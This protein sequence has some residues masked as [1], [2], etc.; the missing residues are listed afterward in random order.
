[1]PQITIVDK[2]KDRE[3]QASASN[4]RKR[5]SDV[6]TSLVDQEEDAEHTAAE[7]PKVKR[8]VGRPPGKRQKVVAAAPAKAGTGKPER[9]PRRSAYIE[10]I[11]TDQAKAPDQNGVE[12]SQSGGESEDDGSLFVT[13]TGQAPMHTRSSRGVPI[14]LPVLGADAEGD[15]GDEGREKSQETGGAEG[16]T[17]IL[18]NPSPE[19]PTPARRS[20]KDYNP[21]PKKPVPS[22]QPMNGSSSGGI[23]GSSRPALEAGAHGEDPAEE[24]E[25][26]QDEPEDDDKPNFGAWGVI[27]SEITSIFGR[28]DHVVNR[29]GCYEKKTAELVKKTP[30]DLAI[31][32][33]LGKQIDKCLGAL[34]RAY[35]DLRAAY[36]TSGDES[37]AHNSIIE[38]F[39]VMQDLLD[40]TRLYL[41]DVSNNTESKID[42]MKDLLFFNIPEFTR[43]LRQAFL[44]HASHENIPVEAQEE[45]VELIELLKTAIDITLSQPDELVPKNHGQTKQ[46]LRGIRSLLRQL[47]EIKS[48]L[49]RRRK[50]IEQE[51][52]IARNR[53]LA[54]TWEERLLK[55]EQALKEEAAKARA[56]RIK[57]AKKSYQNCSDVVRRGIEAELRKRKEL[58]E[59]RMSQS[60]KERWG[61]QDP[62]RSAASDNRG[63]ARS[64]VVEEDGSRVVDD[65]DGRVVDE[66]DSDD[67]FS[68]NYIPR[69]EP[70]PRSSGVFAQY[71]RTRSPSPSLSIPPLSSS[72]PSASP[73]PIHNPSE[74][75]GFGSL[76]ES[77]QKLF[78]ATMKWKYENHANETEVFAHL[79]DTIAGGRYELEDIW[80]VAKSLQDFF[81][82]EHGLGRARRWAWSYEVWR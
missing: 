24:D 64:R 66:D 55:E 39:S 6:S 30:K 18:M 75:F 19:K 7:V 38:Q 70:P 51:R 49:A 36:E 65:D 40:R 58:E 26:G 37:I 47:L 61:T 22:Q 73:E 41:A 45:M 23:T 33:E 1:V 81:D 15:T 54:R 67:P 77:D 43:R 48:E 3:P 52:R 5:R 10:K 32:T 69:P 12:H 56:E 31:K 16:L 29:L 17:E 62:D 71:V 50:A 4:K 76:A 44:S 20:P 68:D 8:P 9:Q 60:E 57:A 21:Q 27:I 72:S 25:A 34:H 35:K 74:P 82:G 79:K 28:L 78:I 2:G 59:W 42:L 63:R 13:E 80:E 53:E 11:T 14:E 46:P